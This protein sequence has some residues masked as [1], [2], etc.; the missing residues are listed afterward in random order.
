MKIT[1]RMTGLAARYLP[2]GSTGSL[3]D[4]EIPDGSTVGALM[5]QL[6]LPSEDSYLVIVSD[7][8]VPHAKRQAH[9]LAEGDMIA[10]VPPLKGG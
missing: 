2:P 8:A 9:H 1:L 7:V 6:G 3:A 4:M 5:R 10:I